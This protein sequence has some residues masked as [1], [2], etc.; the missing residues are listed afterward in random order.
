MNSTEQINTNGMILFTID[1]Y[2]AIKQTPWQIFRP[3]WVY[4]KG[5]HF[6]LFP[7]N[8]SFESHFR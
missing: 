1:F 6:D 5:W 2:Q 7:E 4:F 8:S 3:V